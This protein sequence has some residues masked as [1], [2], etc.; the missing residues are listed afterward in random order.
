MAK[1]LRV[2][3][4]IDSAAIGGAEAVVHMLLRAW[5]ARGAACYVACPRE[6]PMVARYERCAA[7]IATFPRRLWHPLVIL[8]LARWIRRWQIDVVH[9]SLYS[10]D[11]AGILATR[12][13]RRA[14]VVAHLVGHDF[15]VTEERGVR[16]LRK[17]CLSWCYRVIYRWA[18]EVVAVSQAVKDDL[19]LRPGIRV[20][21]VKITVIPHSVWEPDLEI[22]SEQLAHAKQQLAIQEDAVVCVTIGTLIPIKGHRYLLEGMPRL[23]RLLPALRCVVIGDGPQRKVLEQAAARLGLN[24]HVIFAG[25]VD[26][27]LRNAALHLSRVVVLPSLSEGLSV[28]ILEAMALAKPIVTTDVGGNREAVVDGVNGLLVPPRDPEALAVAMRRLVSDEAL[29]ARLGEAGRRRFRE[30]FSLDQML[31]QLETVYAGTS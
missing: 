8:Q 14:R 1:P 21:P 29:A 9:T 10:S 3:F 6:G 30:H 13:S 27:P 15:L 12:L 7:G 4:V 19:A 26:G 2:L 23:V 11:V 24:G 20:P 28:A 5:A 31:Q 17:Q 18:D 25:G 22:S 16:R